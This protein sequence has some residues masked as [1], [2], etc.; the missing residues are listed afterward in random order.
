M[1]TLDE[2][3][4]E[5]AAITAAWEARYQDHEARI[6][7]RSAPEWAW[8]IIDSVLADRAD[9]K[10]PAIGPID[11]GHALRAMMVACERADDEP[12]PHEA[13]RQGLL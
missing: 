8:E 3:E 6:V 13:V 12:I 5:Q 9:W 7:T 2:H 10:I 11:T 4:A 1:S